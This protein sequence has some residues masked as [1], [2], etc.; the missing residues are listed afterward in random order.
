M[1]LVTLRRL[2]GAL[3]HVRRELDAHG[4]WTERLADVDIVLVPIGLAYGWHV[5]HGSGIIGIP[6]VS[7]CRVGDLLYGRR[8]SLRDVLRHEHG[9][10]IAHLHRGLF[11]SRHFTQAF[12]RPHGSAW[13]ED[14]HPDLHVTPYAATAAAEDFAETLMAYLRHGGRWPWRARPGVAQA[15][16]AVRREREEGDPSGPGEVVG[17]AAGDPPCRQP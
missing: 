4:L 6:A 11:R 16:V 10:A 15:E 14:F 2:E 17:G 1:Q 9:H 5:E 7:A 8:T 12:G 3:A 13:E